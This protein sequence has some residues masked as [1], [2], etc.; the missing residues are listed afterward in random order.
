MLIDRTVPTVLLFGTSE[1]LCI[2]HIMT[3]EPNKV[4]IPCLI[5]FRDKKMGD[6][7]LSLRLFHNVIWS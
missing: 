6:A 7:P 4:Q 3:Q 2:F 1:V 5:R